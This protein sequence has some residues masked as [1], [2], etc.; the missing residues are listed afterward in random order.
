MNTRLLVSKSQVWISLYFFFISASLANEQPWHF[1]P[2]LIENTNSEVCDP[3]LDYYKDFHFSSKIRNPFASSYSA[4]SKIQPDSIDEEG[5]PIY[6]K[7]VPSPL[8]VGG[9]QPIQPSENFNYFVKLLEFEDQELLILNI[10]SNT[11]WR[12]NANSQV[13]LVENKDFLNILSEQIN[14]VYPPNRNFKD[15]FYYMDLLEY[16]A[17]KPFGR[18]EISSNDNYKPI[19]EKYVNE[20]TII[21]GFVRD[22]GIYLLAADYNYQPPEMYWSWSSENFQKEEAKIFSLYK[23]EGKNNYKRVCNLQASPSLK[24]EDLP[25]DLKL[26]K[27]AAKFVIGDG[28]EGTSLTYTIKRKNV[29]NDIWRIAK[30]PWA[31]VSNSSPDNGQ[32]NIKKIKEAL[33]NWSRQDI[34]SYKQV[35]NFE[36]GKNNF[37]K[38]LREDNF[39]K[40]KI[41]LNHNGNIEFHWRH[42]WFLSDGFWGYGIN[43]KSLD[44]IISGNLDKNFIFED[45]L[46]NDEPQL[47]FA[48]NNYE[49]LKVLL[50]N[51]TYPDTRNKFGKTTLMYAAQLNLPDAVSLLLENGANPYLETKIIDGWCDFYNIHNKRNALIYAEESNSIESAKI[52]KDWMKIYPK[53]YYQF[54]D[55][56]F[57][58]E[59][60]SFFGNFER[61]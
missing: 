47:S 21:D 39:I 36:N 29:D 44:N 18:F 60:Y 1:E 33:S 49:V 3:L 31:Y 43:K 25:V 8:D 59:F 45:N 13:W 4:F 14:V 46:I 28:C 54:K 7:N 23:Y 50:E 11:G 35:E 27:D 48:L 20:H 42:L 32:N 37:Q 6:P 10:M 16:L 12:Y 24:E 34:W 41:N 52:L 61:M 19:F 53:E 58:N 2:Y 17:G 5:N 55:G 40:E 30:R 56:S 57:L 15:A 26:I 22:D 9:L 51:N 38:L